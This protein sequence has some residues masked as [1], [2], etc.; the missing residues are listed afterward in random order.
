MRESTQPNPAQ[1]A[2]DALASKNPA[3]ILAAI[4]S[5][6]IQAS[7]PRVIALA[8]QLPE[9]QSVVS[10]AATIADQGKPPQADEVDRRAPAQEGNQPKEVTQPTAK[11]K[12][13]VATKPGVS[14]VPPAG[15][16]VAV[17]KAKKSLRVGAP[18]AGGDDAAQARSGVKKA[19][20]DKDP[21]KGQGR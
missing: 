15:M 7:D 20:S 2:R 3:A 6:A 14:A 19:A 12:P 11:G 17:A 18:V 1:Q 5:G 21:N 9:L 13:S 16:Q 8:K 4:Q 10:G